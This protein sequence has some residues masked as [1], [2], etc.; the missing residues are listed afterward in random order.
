M[1]YVVVGNGRMGSAVDARAAAR[2]HERVAVVDTRREGWREALSNARV[3]FE[4]TAPGA[5]AGNIG[6]LI[7]RG[8]S[9]IS[10]TTGWSPDAALRE[11]AGSAGVGVVHAPNFSVGVNAFFRIAER[12]ARL[13]GSVGGYDPAV[14]E[15]HHRGKR[16]VPS[17]TARR[18]AEVVARA[19]GTVGA[20]VEGH[21]AAGIDPGSVHVV[22][23][24]AGAEPGTHTVMFDSAEDRI[25]LCHRARGRGGFAAGAVLAAEWLDERTGWYGFEDILD[26]VLALGER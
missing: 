26:D 13:L 10:G 17:G 15:L 21:P 11:L 2:G 1:R 9:V 23:V 16:D 24:R 4:F 14:V 12:A 6:A 18:L 7:D 8:L 20:P 22:G 19:H 3:A 5:A 25:E